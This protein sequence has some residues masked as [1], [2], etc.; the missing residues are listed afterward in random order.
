MLLFCLEV[1]FWTSNPAYVENMRRLFQGERGSKGLR[2]LV[3]SSLVFELASLLTVAITGCLNDEMMSLEPVYKHLIGFV[4]S[5]AF[6]LLRI[7]T[8]S[9]LQ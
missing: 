2:T 4:L 7:M 8:V 9:V 3:A 6:L 1:I 5:T